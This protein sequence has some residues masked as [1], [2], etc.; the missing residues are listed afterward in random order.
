MADVRKLAWAAVPFAATGLWHRYQRAV[1][2][3]DGL[4]PASPLLP[5]AV[6]AVPTEWGVLAYRTV[7]GD[8]AQPALVLVHGW[9]RSGDSAWWPIVWKTDRTLVVVDLPGHGRSSLLQPFTFELAADAVASAITAEGLERPVL[10]GHSMGGAVA[11]TAAHRMGADAL[12]ALTLIASAAY[13]VKPR[14]WAVLAAAPYVLAPASPVTL[15]RQ[16]REMR[17]TPTSATRVVWEYA[18]R[19]S[20]HLLDETAAALR[21]FDARPWCENGMPPTTWVV[22]TRDGVIDARHQRAS[23]RAMG[24]TIVE[25]IAEHS[26]VSAMPDDVLEILEQAHLGR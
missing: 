5:G 13:W 21:R 17:A 23:G 20:R 25:L 10:V 4:D 8:P 19:P 3:I 1:A 11:L 6:R 22:T 9:G 26:V 16:F 24:A 18:A 12:S 15:R 7:A 2:E 14:L